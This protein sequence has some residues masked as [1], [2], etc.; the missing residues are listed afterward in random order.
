M[1]GREKKSSKKNKTEQTTVNWDEYLDSS[2]SL[3]QILHPKTHA[4]RKGLLEFVKQ[5]LTDSPIFKYS[6][7]TVIDLVIYSLGDTKNNGIPELACKVGV[8]TCVRS[9]QLFKGVTAGLL[10][11]T[12]T[13]AMSKNQ[14]QHTAA[15]TALGA[16]YVSSEEVTSKECETFLS[17]VIVPAIDNIAQAVFKAT[18]LISSSDSIP[19]ENLDMLPT[20]LDVWVAVMLFVTPDYIEA[21]AEKVYQILFE[22]LDVN[23]LELKKKVIDALLN[24]LDLNSR[25]KK[26]VTL[27]L[28]ELNSKLGQL[29]KE[30]DA[31]YLSN[32]FEMIKENDYSTEVPWI[33]LQGGCLS[34]HNRN[35]ETHVHVKQKLSVKK[36]LCSDWMGKCN[37]S[38]FLPKP[39]WASHRKVSIDPW[40]LPQDSYSYPFTPPSISTIY[41]A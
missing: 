32:I 8:L 25:N 34:F 24:L 19:E 10:Q 13:S 35:Y 22:L 17:N 18:N 36:R 40:H 5:A 38:N 4:L 20:L 37:C 11:L 12:E 7:D 23:K 2:T 1:H 31:N 14:S 30:L 21:N 41:R 27:P 6:M 39:T 29:H 28:D 3:E 26:I 15:I 16:I 9:S 33:T